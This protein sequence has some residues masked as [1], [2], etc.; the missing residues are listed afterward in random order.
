M[1]R[2][3]ALFFSLLLALSVCGCAAGDWVSALGEPDF[4]PAESTALTDTPDADGSFTDP[5]AVAL[6]LHVY[7]RLPGNFITKRDAKALGWDSSAGNLDAVAPGKSIG[8][9]VFG[10]YEG[11]LPDADGR[12]W[13][14]CDV[15]YA[16]GYR[17]AERVIY[18]DD[19]LIFYTADHY[20]SF[21]QFY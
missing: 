8:G 3:L 1:K 9:D 5:R 20:A 18:S 10:N 15:N 14:E 16:G 19:G 6:Y 12:V 11:L 21:E 13:R 7:G 2:T 4:P 17:G